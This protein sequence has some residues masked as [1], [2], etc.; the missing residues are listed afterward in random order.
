MKILHEA[1]VRSGLGQEKH[2]QAQELHV[3]LIGPR[4]MRHMN[5]DYLG[6]DYP[7]DVLAFD[8]SGFEVGAVP[9]TE[10]QTRGEIYV[11][12]Q[13]A[14]NACED[15]NTCVAYELVLY[16]VHGMLHLVGEKDQTE[17]QKERMKK[18]ER[19]VME[20]IVKRYDLNSVFS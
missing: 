5:R 1:A 20:H 16:V 18:R 12:P 11:C 4:K 3:I 6:H 19:T 13:V 9:R 2:W 15:Y 14:I 10:T 17:M 8:L 7:T